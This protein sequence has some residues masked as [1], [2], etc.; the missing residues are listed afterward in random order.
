VHL[1]FPRLL[2]DEQLLR[3]L[4]DA[5]LACSLVETDAYRP[6]NERDMPRRVVAVSTDVEARPQDG[7]DFIT[8][9]DPERRA[10]V[11]RDLEVGLALEVNDPLPGRERDRET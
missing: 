2:A 5:F 3:G 4:Q 7:D 10:R 6:V 8:G 9:N 11:R 1:D